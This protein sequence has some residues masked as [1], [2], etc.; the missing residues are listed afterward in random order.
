MGSR[1]SISGKLPLEVRQA[2]SQLGDNIRL[3][4]QRRRMSQDDVA[5]ACQ[6]T[7]KTVYSLEKGDPGTSLGTA[8]SV[9]WAL[10]L[11]SSA[12]ALA[13]PDLDEHGKI[14]DAARQPKRVRQPAPADT[15]F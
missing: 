15:D 12:Q 8:F 6:V 1:M 4:R 2:I 14:L 11:L 9:V 10:G 7:R 5:K 13:N 3:A